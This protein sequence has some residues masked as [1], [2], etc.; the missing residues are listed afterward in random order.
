MKLTYR[1]TTYDYVP[2]TVETVADRLGNALR[3]SATKLRRTDLTQP[4]LRLMYRGNDYVFNPTEAASPQ[5][6]VAAKPVELFYRG[7]RY[8][9]GAVPVQQAQQESFAEKTRLLTMQQCQKVE[10]REVA[11][12]ERFAEEVASAAWDEPSL[13]QASHI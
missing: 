3:N 13:D 7:V 12:L 10:Q 8:V 2:S 11:T 5:P 1:G 6:A 4:A 9:K